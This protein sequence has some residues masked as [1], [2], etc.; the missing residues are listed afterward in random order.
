MTVTLLA[1]VL[2]WAS[3]FLATAPRHI[4]PAAAYATPAIRMQEGFTKKDDLLLEEEIDRG[5]VH[6][7]ALL[8]CGS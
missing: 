7:L 2:P 6:C 4:V 1:S 5:C 3:A 8:H